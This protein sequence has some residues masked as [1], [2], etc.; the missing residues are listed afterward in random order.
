MVDE[1]GFPH[2][3]FFTIACVILQHRETGKLEGCTALGTP[4]TVHRRDICWMFHL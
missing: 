2:M 1:Q 4:S 3:S